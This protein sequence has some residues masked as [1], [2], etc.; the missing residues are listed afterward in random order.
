MNFRK[1]TFSILTLFF[2]NCSLLF[3]LDKNDRF[4]LKVIPKFE[5]GGVV[6]GSSFYGDKILARVNSRE[7]ILNEKQQRGLYNQLNTDSLGTNITLGAGW[8]IS[9]DVLRL[10]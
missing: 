8:E 9:G 2:V 6:G 10:V 1:M 3:S 4:T 7:L 5:T